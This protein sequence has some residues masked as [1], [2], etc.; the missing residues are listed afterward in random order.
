M[1]SD[2]SKKVLG[3]IASTMIMTVMFAVPVLAYTVRGPISDS[4]GNDLGECVIEFE[5]GN[6]LSYGVDI[7]NQSYEATIN[8]TVTSISVTV[9][10]GYAVIRTEGTFS[11]LSPAPS[12]WLDRL[13]VRTPGFVSDGLSLNP[14][15]NENGLSSIRGTIRSLGSS[16]IPSSYV[17]ETHKFVVDPYFVK[18]IT[19]SEGGSFPI[20]KDNG[21]E[22]AWVGNELG[23]YSGEG[24]SRHFNV[25]S[26]S[27]VKLENGSG[28]FTANDSLNYG[29]STS[30]S[31]NDDNKEEDK[32]EPQPEK[33]SSWSP[34]PA[35][36]QTPAQVATTQLATAQKTLAALSVIPSASKEVFKTNGMALNMTSVNTVDAN[37]TKLIA[38]NSD[39]PYNV[40]FYFMGKPTVCTI[41]A[42]FNYASYIKPD[43]SM[44]IHEVLWAVYSNQLRQQTRQRT[45]RTR[46]RGR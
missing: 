11:G 3:F 31:H 29:P 30:S 34:A 1:R 4:N 2:L 37:T 32:P 19:R 28:T 36:S 38:A 10:N 44:N 20:H 8:A 45:T 18:I 22:L 15:R 24:E 33:K 13:A 5:S 35:A 43:G 12:T 41:P 26:L 42:G 23:Y 27:D 21:N 39:I 14:D 17:G 9:Y 16:P 6:G 7:D 46:T 40:T 25:C